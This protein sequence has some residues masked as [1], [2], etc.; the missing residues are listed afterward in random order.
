VCLELLGVPVG[1]VLEEQYGFVVQA[2][3]IYDEM[4]NRYVF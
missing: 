3:E 2:K 4:S 1:F